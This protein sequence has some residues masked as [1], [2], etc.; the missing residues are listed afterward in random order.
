MDKDLQEFIYLSHGLN[1]LSEIITERLS[2]PLPKK[3]PPPFI[4]QALE[5]FYLMPIKQQR[6]LRND[7]QGNTRTTLKRKNTG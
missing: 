5:R 3:R 6:R 1:C 4:Q 7:R 2:R